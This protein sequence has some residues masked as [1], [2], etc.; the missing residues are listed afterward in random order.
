MLRRLAYAWAASLLLPVMAGEGYRWRIDFADE[1]RRPDMPE[2]YSMGGVT[3]VSNSTYWAVTDEKRRPVVW[4]LELPV[5]SATGKVTGCQMRILCRPEASNDIEAIARDP[6]DGTI[7]LTD[8]RAGTINQ[9]DPMTG[10]RLSGRVEVPDCMKRSRLDFGMESLAISGDG[11]SMWTCAEEALEQD[12]PLA[13]RKSGSA[14]RLTKLSRATAA[15]AWRA[16][17]QWV[18]NSDPVA[19]KPWYN[20]KG[21][22][23]ARSG[24]S[25]LCVLED[26]TLLVLE[27]EFS[28]VIV[29]R[30]RCRIYETDFT[31][32]TEVLARASLKDGASAVAVGKRL[33][34]EATG[35]SMYEGMCLGPRLADGSRI[36]ML[37][38]D[39]DKKSLRTVLS[40]RLSRR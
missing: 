30:F 1:V 9:H 35:F 5:D 34:Y 3:W 19:G 7:W 20:S 24:I 2:A 8:E 17:A 21:E 39:G 28:V 26:G 36:L 22:N 10:K 37:V 11:L 23:C 27:R 32:A 40:L 14:I 29:P 31:S 33:L 6:L 25:E 15:D 18:Y 16:S 38:S 12:G 4:E 13:T